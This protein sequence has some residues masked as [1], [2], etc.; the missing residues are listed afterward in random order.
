VDQAKFHRGAGSTTLL[1]ARGRHPEGPYPLGSHCVWLDSRTLLRRDALRSSSALH[2]WGDARARSDGRVD[3]PMGARNAMAAAAPRPWFALRS[4]RGHRPCSTR[5]I[6]GHTRTHEPAPQLS[7]PRHVARL[8]LAK[9]PRGVRLGLRAHGVGHSDSAKA[10]CAYRAAEPTIS[11][12]SSRL[13]K[14][15][16]G[17]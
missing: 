6:V 2:D 3:H 15:V 12:Q 11:G 9:R 16:Q 1:W 17:F 4:A 8:G 14:T 13:W 5:Q 10:G 7:C